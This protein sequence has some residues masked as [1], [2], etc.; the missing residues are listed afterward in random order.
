MAGGCALTRKPAAESIMRV[1]APPP[2][3][4]PSTPRSGLIALAPVLARGSA[5][6]RRYVYINPAAPRE[7]QQAATLFW[8]E[9]PPRLVERALSLGLSARLGAPVVAADQAPG[10]ERRLSVRVDRWEEHAGPTAAAAI[11][12]DAAVIDLKGRALGFAKSYCA[13]A[14]IPSDSPSARA[15]A[16]E[17]ALG[18]VLDALAA[19]LARAPAAVQ[20]SSC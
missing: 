4:R 3:V 19:D 1:E 7:V 15:G 13:S 20:P 17:T 2:A 5:A 14:P 16:F 12:L 10:A 9:P 8:E 18:G 11:Q 6:D